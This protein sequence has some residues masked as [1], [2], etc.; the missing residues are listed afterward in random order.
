[1]RSRQAASFSAGPTAAGPLVDFL[2]QM[3]VAGHQMPGV[4]LSRGSATEFNLQESP[5]DVASGRVLRLVVTWLMA[6]AVTSGGAAWAATISGTN[7]AD[8]LTGTSRADRIFGR[9]D[10]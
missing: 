6:V 3:A 2:E 9:Q 8:R 4:E 5:A 7:R 10:S 1:M